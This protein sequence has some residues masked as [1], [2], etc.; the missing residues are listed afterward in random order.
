MST[1]LRLPRPR[2]PYQTTTSEEFEVSEGAGRELGRRPAS[3]VHHFTSMLRQN[4]AF[5]KDEDSVSL[6]FTDKR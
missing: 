2:Q 4:V 3:V 1:V 6:Y 5:D